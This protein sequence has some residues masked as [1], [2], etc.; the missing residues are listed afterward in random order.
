[1]IRTV[2]MFG[3]GGEWMDQWYRIDN[4]GK[5]FHAVSD[6]TNSSVFRV[7]MIL[8]EM[9]EPE[10]LQEALDIVAV[11]FPTLTVRVRK[12]L[13]WDFMEHNDERL[14]VKKEEDYPCAPIDRKENNAYLIRVLYFERRIS[15]EIF[16]SLTDG[17]GA[18]EFLKTLIYQYLKEKGERVEA[19]GLILLPE[20]SPDPEEMEDSFEKYATSHSMKRPGRRPRK[21]YQIHGAAFEPPGINVIHGVLDASQLNAFA[22]RH[23]TSLT[24]F[25]TSLLIKVIHTE[26]M[27]ADMTDGIVSVALPISLRKQFPSMTLRNFFSVANIGIPMDGYVHFEDVIEAVT[28]Q[29][30]EKTDKESLQTVINRF[31]S[32]QSSLWTRAVPVFLKYPFM[33]FGFNQIGERAKT[34]TL[35]NLGKIQLPESMEAHVDRMEVILY[36]TRKSPINIGIGTLNDQLTI[37]F[38]RSIEDNDIIQAFFTELAGMT[39]LDIKVYSN[40]WG[41]EV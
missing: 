7:S 35:S 28:R 18:V 27:T 3:R 36:P 6:A 26:K 9:I 2:Y 29:L 16:H 1:M 12:G 39:E 13:F 30:M 32:L 41:E 33:R 10:Y 31:V 14:L 24:G 23:G 40:E 8:N 15:V 20:E 4:T 19:K 17:G 5:I 25:L 21:A 34:M 38:A 22:K 37:T 11:R